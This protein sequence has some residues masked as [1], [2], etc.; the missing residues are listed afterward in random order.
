MG[1]RSGAPVAFDEPANRRQRHHPAPMVLE[2]IVS[3]FVKRAQRGVRTSDLRFRSPAPRAQPRRLLARC[4]GCDGPRGRSR[5]PRRHPERH[6]A[7]ASPRPR[8]S[9]SWAPSRGAVPSAPVSR[10][11][12]SS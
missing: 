6:P 11:A 4:D 10:L 3:G 12:P 5:R 8:D 1:C 9:R 7:S 2:L